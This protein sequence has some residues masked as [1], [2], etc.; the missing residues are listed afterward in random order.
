MHVSLSTTPTGR[1]E[2]YVS[3]LATGAFLVSE[4]GVCLLA[5]CYCSMGFNL[6]VTSP[7]PQL[8]CTSE[9]KEETS[10]RKWASQTS[11]IESQLNVQRRQ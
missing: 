4:R 3:L 1:S 8:V 6:I 9:I 10:I 7:M 2:L 5:K 11:I